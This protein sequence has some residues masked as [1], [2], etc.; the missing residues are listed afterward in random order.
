M[1]AYDG[2]MTFYAADPADPILRA[3]EGVFPTLFQPLDA[4]AG[5]PPRAPAR[6]RGA[7]RRPDPDVRDVPRDRPGDVLPR[8]PTCGPCPTRAGSEQTLPDRGLLR[9]D[10]DAGRGGHGV[11]AAPADG[12]GPAAE[13]D[14]LG[15]RAQR[16]SRIRRRCASSASRRTPRSAGP[17]QIEAQI[18]ADPHDQRPDHASGTRPAARSCAGNLIVVPV[19]DSIVYLQPIYL[20]STTSAFPAFQKI[21][22]ATST[23][24]VWGNTLDGGA[25]AAAGGRHQARPRRRPR[26][27]TPQPRSGSPAPSGHAGARPA[28][29][30][31][32]RR[33]ATWRRWSPT[34]TST[35]SW[36]RR[37]CAPAT[38][39][40]TA[41]RSRPS[42][43]RWPSSASSSPRR[44][45][46]AVGRARPPA[47]S[48]ERRREP[49]R[50]ASAG[51]G[52]EPVR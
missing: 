34:R 48:A 29:R 39:P 31:R 11:P 25:A 45:P 5:R 44:A 8:R 42:R 26:R 35:S 43:R 19:Q 49:D 2:T 3:Y 47:A 22:V 41:R 14:R 23:K 15:R 1:D 27:P 12:A 32:R 46:V 38:S 36:P 16:R 30:S 21:V 33:P 50:S 13:H 24:I 10:A 37:R 17:N 20:Q 28:A 52:R 6:S 18:D 40:A 51:F 7:V 4:D 9:G